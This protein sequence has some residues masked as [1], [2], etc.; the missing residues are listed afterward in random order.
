[1][2]TKTEYG[3]TFHVFTDDADLA[4]YPGGSTPKLYKTSITLIPKAD[5]YTTKRKPRPNI[6]AAHRLKNTQILNKILVNRM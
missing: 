4:F 6:P 5:K 1:M 2:L 3:N